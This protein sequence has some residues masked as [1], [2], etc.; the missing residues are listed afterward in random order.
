MAM[1][2]RV[3]R[4]RMEGPQRIRQRPGDVV[5]WGW[6]HG[7]RWGAFLAARLSFRREPDAMLDLSKPELARVGVQR[8]YARAAPLH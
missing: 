3:S 2:N 8:G 6:S 1:R 7:S 4:A 5:S